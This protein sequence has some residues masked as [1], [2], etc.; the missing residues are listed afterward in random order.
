MDEGKRKDIE[1]MAIGP[2]CWGRGDTAT[3][4]VER[5]LVNLPSPGVYGPSRG[6]PFKMVVFMGPKSAEMYV[7]GMG[8]LS[9]SGERSDVEKVEEKDMVRTP[10]I[11]VVRDWDGENESRAYLLDDAEQARRK[12]KEI[13]ANLEEMYDTVEVYGPDW[14]DDPDQ[15]WTIDAYDDEE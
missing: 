8:G 10:L 9:W 3:D 4:A 2:H 6:D 5:A 11:K 13:V 14:D 15:D 7:T 1:Y 12:A